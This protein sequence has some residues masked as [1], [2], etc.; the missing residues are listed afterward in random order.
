MMTDL[1]S[2]LNVHGSNLFVN[3]AHGLE[4]GVVIS[5]LELTTQHVLQLEDGHAGLL[6]VLCTG[7]GR[8]FSTHTRKLNEQWSAIVACAC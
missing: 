4:R 8:W 6:V 3:P 2:T 5:K 1:R 7:R